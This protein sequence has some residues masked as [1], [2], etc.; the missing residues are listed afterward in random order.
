MDSSKLFDYNRYLLIHSLRCSSPLRGIFSKLCR[1]CCIFGWCKIQLTKYLKHVKILSALQ[2]SVKLNH[3]L[4]LA[5]AC[6]GNPDF[7]TLKFSPLLNW[8]SNLNVSVCSCGGICMFSHGPVASTE[9]RCCHPSFVHACHLRCQVF[10]GT[11]Y[12]H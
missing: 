1:K 9:K 6:F 2:A 3:S 5:D 4:L 11:F 12:G 7:E 8:D 10:C